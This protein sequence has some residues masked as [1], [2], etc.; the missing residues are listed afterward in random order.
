MPLMAVRVN[1]ARSCSC[2]DPWG[3]WD[4]IRCRGGDK[5]TKD[6]GEEKGREEGRTKETERNA[7]DTEEREERRTIGR[8]CGIAGVVRIQVLVAETRLWKARCW[9][10]DGGTMTRRCKSKISIVGFMKWLN[11]VS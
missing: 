6:A 1:P 4:G 7:S 9:V 2:T 8:S 3:D 11:V 5:E 10:D